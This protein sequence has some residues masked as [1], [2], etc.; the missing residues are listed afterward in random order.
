MKRPP[1]SLCWYCSSATAAAVIMQS[2]YSV[3]RNS[4]SSLSF[5]ESLTDTQTISAVSSRNVIAFTSCTDLKDNDPKSRQVD[6]YVA[7][8]NVPNE[9]YKVKS[10]S[11]EITCL[12]WDITSSRIL[13]GDA[14]GCIE[15][16]SMSDFLLSEWNETG[17]YCCFAGERILT[18]AWFH[19]GYKLAASTDK[20]DSTI[21]SEKFVSVKFGASVRQFAGK[22]CDGFLAISSTGLV[23]SLA[24]MT[25]ESVVTGIEPLTHFR[26]QLKAVDIS[27]A[28][29]GHFL[30]IASNGRVSSS[31]NCYTIS[32]KVPLS[33]SPDTNKCTITC[34]PFSSFY[35]NASNTPSD[36]CSE[37][38]HLNFVLKEAAEAVV[39]ATRG[40][41]GSTVQ[42][43]ELQEQPVVLHKTFQPKNG[44]D[45]KLPKT[46]AI[47]QHHASHSHTVPVV[48][49]AT[50]RLSVLDV[51][52]PPSYIIV[53][54]EDNTI[55][56]MVRE[57]LKEVDHLN[58]SSAGKG[59]DKSRVKTMSTI[60]KVADMQF[61]WNG[62]VLI[63][64]NSFSELQALRLIPIIEANS[65]LPGLSSVLLMLEYCLLTGYDCWDILIG[66][67]GN[68]FETLYEQLHSGFMKQAVPVQQRLL[69]RLHEVKGLM[70]RSV[71]ASSSGSPGQVKAGDAYATIMLTAVYTFLKSLLR[72]RDNQ[73]K[74]GP[75]E[76]VNTLIQTKGKDYLNVDKVV[77]ELEHKEFLVE[78]GILQS[79]QNLN[80]WVADLTLYLLSSLPYQ[81]HDKQRFPGGYL[82]HETKFLN[83]LRELLVIMRI[84][85][86]INEN[87]LPLF[88]TLNGDLDVIAHL[89]KLLTVRVCGVGSE[90]EESLLE[91]C[92]RLT[93]QVLVNQPDL[94]LKARGVL[95]PPLSLPNASPLTLS[96]FTDSPALS[97]DIKT[98]VIEGAVMYNLHRRMD[99]IRHLSLG[100]LSL[101]PKYGPPIRRCTRCHA[102]SLISSNVV[103]RFPSARAW[104]QR[105][106]ER[107]ICSGSWA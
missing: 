41:S 89:F 69:M 11:E 16:W 25:E 3:T 95:S 40:P 101:D 86:L 1:L 55:K 21:Y 49:V 68:N 84:W 27:Y 87:C 2:I 88:T 45:E 46:V 52:P 81:V 83:M 63:L 67:K 20:K 104:D 93:N 24:Y 28:R 77:M 8:L 102:V 53:A 48:C 59:D 7:D 50:P 85:G 10:H 97:V 71:P 98:H 36:S 60:F 79:V 30:V 75:G 103:V 94:C 14:V 32:I 23:W 57:N 35:L 99:I 73:E 58:L 12:Q 44:S 47:W 18:A 19:N 43:W 105:F 4:S 17:S 33:S 106:A 78:T 62:C 39:V 96:Y 76:S 26:S 38:T 66:L 31:I 100:P 22:P 9:V 70:Y 90:P 80:Q 64:L 92:Y 72:A 74:E 42:V 65:S 107:C 91:E 13:I 5:P 29:N 6:V 54:Y 37:I 82:V 34:Q 61:S 56:C 15:I 51:T